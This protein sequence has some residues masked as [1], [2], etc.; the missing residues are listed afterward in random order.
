M[1]NVTTAGAASESDLVNSELAN[2]EKGIIPMG[3]A[4]VYEA[5]KDMPPNQRDAIRWFFAYTKEKGYSMK[6]AAAQ[7]KKDTST[8]SR[9]FS[10]TYNASVKE[11][12]TAIESFKRIAEQRDA[13]TTI[14]FVP[15]S[16]SRKIFSLV[17]FSL[18]SNSVGFI[19][20]NSQIGKTLSLEEIKR[21]HSHGVVKY[22]RMPATPGVQLLMQEI[23]HACNVNKDGCFTHLRDQVIKSLD[24]NNVL[25][26]DEIHEA[27]QAHQK[28]TAIAVFEMLRE[29]HDRTKC[30][31]VLCGTNVARDHFH[32]GEHKK[33]L[34]QLLRRG[35]GKLQLPQVAPRDDLDAIA[36]AYGLPPATDDAEQLMNVIMRES[37]LGTFTKFLSAASNYAA[38]RKEKPTWA[39]FVRAH[40]MLAKL[41]VKEAA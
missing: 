13:I 33:I 20:G 22:V 35:V 36:K 38:N 3:A 29:I 28:R 12:V 30:G 10:G 5:T 7:I 25:I 9:I 21:R 31:L 24:K 18:A 14:G 15:T 17:E 41:S 39:H 8:I 40:D 23:A 26:V 27:M 37:G 2:I 11:V 34:E 6:T 32:E 1:S 4:K 19:Y 16:I